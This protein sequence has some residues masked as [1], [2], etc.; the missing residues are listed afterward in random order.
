MFIRFGFFKHISRFP[1][2][3]T[4]P[5]TS[6]SPKSMSEKSA[7]APRTLVSRCPKAPAEE[8]L[9]CVS[10]FTLPSLLLTHQA[11]NIHAVFSATPF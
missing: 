3:S 2:P 9:K 10:H 6:S 11:D 7:D 1:Q 4:C 5:P 8:R